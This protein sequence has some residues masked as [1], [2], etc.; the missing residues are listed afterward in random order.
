ME[1]LSLISQVH[2]RLLCDRFG[3]DMILDM[4]QLLFLNRLELHLMPNVIFSAGIGLGA[5][6]IAVTLS[7]FHSPVTDNF[8]NLMNW[9]GF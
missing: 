8:V 7:S 1:N 5:L 9:G 4:F 6:T 2:L 3:N